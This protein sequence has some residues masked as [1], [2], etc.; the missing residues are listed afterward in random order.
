MH[1]ENNPLRLIKID[2]FY[3]EAL[4]ELEIKVNDVRGAYIGESFILTTSDKSYE[5][6]F[7]KIGEVLSDAE[8]KEEW[9]KDIKSHCIK[10][11]EDYVECV[12]EQE[13]YDILGVDGGMANESENVMEA[14]VLAF[15]E[16]RLSDEELSDWQGLIDK[17]V[18]Q[19][20]MEY[21]ADEVANKV[22]KLKADGYDTSELIDSLDKLKQ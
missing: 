13:Y 18:K 6:V 15:N 20:V 1:I 11:I 17:T 5:Q 12:Y 10:N 9:I 22:K 4:K 8:D 3:G 2:D 16:G 7:K 19:H 14:I 21:V